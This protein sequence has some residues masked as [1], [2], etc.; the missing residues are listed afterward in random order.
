M[1]E[2]I[3]ICNMFMVLRLLFKVVNLRFQ[4]MNFRF[5]LFLPLLHE[6][7]HKTTNRQGYREY[8]FLW[9]LLYWKEAFGYSL[10]YIFLSY[11]ASL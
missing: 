6:L 4:I 7:R 9:L 2:P 11:L 5:T 1:F 3:F 8:F 10:R